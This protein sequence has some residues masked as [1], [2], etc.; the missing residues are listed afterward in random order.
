MTKQFCTA[1]S[2]PREHFNRI[3]TVVSL[4]ASV[5]DV[6]QLYREMNLEYGVRS[7]CID[8]GVAAG[9]SELGTHWIPATFTVAQRLHLPIAPFRKLGAATSS[10]NCPVTP[11]GHLAPTT[12]HKSP[13][14]P[15][16]FKV[17]QLLLALQLMWAMK[18]IRKTP[19]A[20]L[21]K[22]IWE[23]TLTRDEKT[24]LEERLEAGSLVLPGRSVLFNACIKV[25]IA[26]SVYQRVL[27]S[28]FDGIRF[29][30]MDS[31][32]QKNVN[33]YVMREERF[34]WDKDLE[35]EAIMQLDLASLAESR[36]LPLSVLG[37]GKGTV[38]SK[39]KHTY[40]SLMLESGSC[41]TNGGDKRELLPP[42][43]G[44]K[45]NWPTAGTFANLSVMGQLP[46]KHCWLSKL[47]P[48]R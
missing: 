7:L 47:R 12:A 18:G 6:Q 40:S 15:Y 14:V 45:A 19:L 27:L 16:R 1:V 34:L 28:R 23:L 41:G 4:P 30:S 20:W 2:I 3:N 9:A 37:Y 35:P 13:A 8:G 11:L 29:L 43:R 44:S 42:T 5:P 25:D 24:R 21:C 33:Y 38:V 17:P 48:K 32:K 10:S 22:K 31:G 39:S 26:Q 36:R 46:T